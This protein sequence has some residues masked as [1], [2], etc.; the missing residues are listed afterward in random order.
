MLY[1]KASMVDEV[2]E[3]LGFVEDVVTEGDYEYV[4]HQIALIMRDADDYLDVFC[5]DFRYSDNPVVCTVSESLADCYQS[6]RN[7]VESF[8]RGYDEA[9]EVSL[10]ECL[11]DFSQHWGQQLLGALRAIHELLA[12]GLAD[13]L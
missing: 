12:T 1:L 5:Q 4:R 13:E 10:Y 8:R 2:E 6:L 3:G 9:M 7:M 11:Q